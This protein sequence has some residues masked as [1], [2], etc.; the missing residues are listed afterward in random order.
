MGFTIHY[1]SPI[2]SKEKLQKLEKEYD[3]I[4]LGVGLGQT[5][6]LKLEGENKKG[7]IG[8]VEFIEELRMKQ[9]LVNVPEN[10]VVIGGGN[11]AMDAASESARMGA[12]KTVLVYRN[13]KDRMGAYGF[14][15]DL[16]ISS[17]VDS[18]FNATPVE[19]IGDKKAEGVK[20]L[21]TES[22]NGQLKTINESEFIIACDLVIK[23]TG[24]S[25]IL[26]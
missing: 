19:V 2:D 23:A 6:E 1:E 22:V 11:T 13:D 5:R 26:I 7:V 12:R 16:A 14:E 8:A 25:L 4:F 24:L 10:V 17:G 9:H 15:Y 3:A 20:F 21:K 18:V